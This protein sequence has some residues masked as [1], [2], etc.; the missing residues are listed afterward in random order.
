MRNPKSLIYFTEK[1]KPFIKFIS[2]TMKIKTTLFST[3]II[4]QIC[5]TAQTQNEYVFSPVPIVCK[6]HK[7]TV[8]KVIFSPDGSILYTCGGA[9]QI[10]S[11]NSNDG[12]VL[13]YAP[14]NNLDE[15]YN[16]MTMNGDGTLLAIAGYYN[17]RIIIFDAIT[18]SEKFSITGFSSFDDICFSPT[19]NMIAISGI[20]KE[21]NKQVVSIYDVN[22]GVQLRELW[23]QGKNDAIP[24]ALGF[25]PDG[26]ILACGFSNSGKGIVMFSVENGEKINVISHTDDVSALHYS[27]DGLFIASGGT[28]N[29][30]TIWDAQTREAILILKGMNDFIS[31]IDYS[32]DGKYIV[33]AGMD[34]SCI[35]KM[36]DCINGN[37]IQSIDQPG[38]DIMSL[39]FS[40]D[41]NS[42]AVGLRTY[43]NLFEVTTTCIFHKE[44]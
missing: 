27:P 3:L 43:G 10:A 2:K 29:N 19:S 38:P 4:V 17:D 13:I 26:T 28:D 16:F 15:T 22:T 14:E 35:F 18:L 42:L 32:P 36:W 21:A 25:N 6:F 12:S 20:S 44:K 34:N 39:C 30:V 9:N 24:T 7:T 31:T 23:A 11:F 5:I 8:N 33:A 40:P 41:G 37:L 1:K